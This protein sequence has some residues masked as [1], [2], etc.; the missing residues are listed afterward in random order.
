MTENIRTHLFDA[1]P[2]EPSGNNEFGYWKSVGL[3]SLTCF[4]I[5][6]C[7]FTDSKYLLIRQVTT[8]IKE[9]ARIQKSQAPY[10]WSQ[11]FLMVRN[12][13]NVT[14]DFIFAEVEDAFENYKGEVFYRLS[15]GS[16]FI[17]EHKAP[18][19]TFFNGPTHFS[20]RYSKP[21]NAGE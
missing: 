5:D 21:R 1:Q 10:L 18:E 7:V 4:I 15:D 12:P 16:T 8:S 3:F 11:V 2:P 13:T 9:A 17:V 14:T 19:S 20:L 6:T